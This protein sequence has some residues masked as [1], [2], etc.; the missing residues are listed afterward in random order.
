MARDRRTAQS[1]ENP[2]LNFVRFGSPQSIEAATKAGQIFARQTGDQIGV[3]VHPAVLPQKPNIGIHELIVLAPPDTLGGVFIEG[4]H[5]DLE[6]QRPGRELH[7]HL[8]ELFG[9]AIGHHLEVNK[10]AVVFAGQKELENAR[11]CLVTEVERAIDEAKLASAAPMQRFEIGEQ[12]VSKSNCRTLIGSAD[13]QN[14]HVN[15]QPR[16]AST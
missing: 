9:K 2:Q 11:R 14:S 13:R 15:G 10:N 3:N 1:F 16:D 5:A 7:H 6:L 8:F 4:L 12:R